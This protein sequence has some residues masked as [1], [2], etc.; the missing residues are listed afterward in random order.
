MPF[1]AFGLGA[2][3]VAFTLLTS[4]PLHADT[5]YSGAAVH[6]DG[7]VYSWGVTS[8]CSMSSHTTHMS[9]TLTSPRGGKPTAQQATVAPAGLT[10]AW[11]PTSPTWGRTRLSVT[12]GHSVRC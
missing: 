3:V 12:R 7:S 9:S 10:S 8:A 11:P 5:F 2:F 6:S 4:V 1:L